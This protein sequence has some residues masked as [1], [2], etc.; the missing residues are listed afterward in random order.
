MIERKRKYNI[1]GINPLYIIFSKKNKKRSDLV[2]GNY[3]SF[4][5][6]D[7][8]VYRVRKIFKSRFESNFIEVESLTC[9]EIDSY[10]KEY[11]LVDTNANG[12][13]YREEILMDMVKNEEIVLTLRELKKVVDA[14]MDDLID[15]Y[16]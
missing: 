4:L 16:S 10:K 9:K 15:I 11:F 8:T 3:N 13:W 1:E 12:I 2:M 5:K 7:Q 6:I 14:M